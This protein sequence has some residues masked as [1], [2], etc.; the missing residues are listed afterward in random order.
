MSQ[1]HLMSSPLGT[2]GTVSVPEIIDSYFTDI[3]ASQFNRQYIKR[4]RQRMECQLW[5]ICSEKLQPR[6]TFETGP[7]HLIISAAES[8]EH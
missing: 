7:L 2:C 5:V 1:N 6:P 3:N 8:H 4:T